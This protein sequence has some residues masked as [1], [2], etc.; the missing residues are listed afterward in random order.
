[1]PGLMELEIGLY[2]AD[3]LGGGEVK[4]LELNGLDYLL[5]LFFFLFHFFPPPLPV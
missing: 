2:L 4:G 3:F 5:S 1:M